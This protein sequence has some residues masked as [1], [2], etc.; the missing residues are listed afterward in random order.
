MADRFEA[1]QWNVCC[2]RCGQEFKA[3]QLRLEWTNLRVCHGIGTN[4]CWE[5]RNAQ[6]KVKGVAD[7]QAPPWVRPEP[8]AIE[9]GINEVQA[10]DL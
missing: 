5:P 1:G 4:G 7:R 8:P 9:L 2:D 3:R 6:E 10:D